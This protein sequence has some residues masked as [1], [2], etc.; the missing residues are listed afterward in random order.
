MA[1]IREELGEETIKEVIEDVTKDTGI[2]KS[3]LEEYR[4]FIENST[5]EEIKAQR[6]DL[7][8]EEEA[9]AMEIKERENLRKEME[10]GGIRRQLSIINRNLL[11][12]KFGESKLKCIITRL[13]I[14]KLMTR[15]GQSPKIKLVSIADNP[16]L[17][18]VKEISKKDEEEI[19]EFIPVEERERMFK[20]K[21]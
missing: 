14:G 6:D 15:A 17:G 20:R 18:F 16:L 7:L 1:T 19:E 9:I 4:E 8:V 10:I 2:E 21:T 12:L 13:K 5:P 11:R 3:V